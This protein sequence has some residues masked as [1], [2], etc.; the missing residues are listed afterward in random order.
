MPGS[1]GAHTGHPSEPTAAPGY[2]RVAPSGGVPAGAAPPVPAAA[3]TSS[4]QYGLTP[5]QATTRPG[6]PTAGTGP[7]MPTTTG[8]VQPSGPAPVAAPQAFPAAPASPSTDRSAASSLNLDGAPVRLEWWERLGGLF[9]QFRAFR[10][11]TRVRMVLTWV[12]LLIVA[13]TLAVSPLAR[14][15]LG[16]W[17]GCFWIVAV[18]FWLARG[19]TVSWGM[20]SGIFALSMP[21]AGAVGWLSFQVAAAARVPVDHAASQVVIAGVVEEL[22]KLAP[23]CL[24][25]VIA[26]GRVRRLLIQDWLVLGVA[27]G[28]G[29]MAV[30]E[31]ARR[32][33]YVLGNTPGLQLSKAVCPEDPEGIIECI[34]AHTFSLWPFADAFPGPVT[35]A[36]HAIVT[37]LVAVSIGLARHLWW[38]ARHHHPAFGVA[39]RCMALGLPLGVLWVAIVDHMATNSTT[40]STNWFTG[41]RVVKAWGATK[42]EAPWP[43]VGTTSSMAG[44]GQGR[45]WLLLVMLVVALLL[46]ARVMRLGGYA[47]V[48]GGPGGGPGAPQGPTGGVAGRWGADVVEATAAARAKAHRL[49][50]GLAQAATTRRPRLF[51]QAW[52]EHRIA[53]DLAARRALD[54]GPHRWATSALAAAAALAGAWIINT[55]V[56]PAVTELNQRLNGL[57][58]FWFAGI[59]DTLAAV[60][61]SMSPTEKAA[62]VLIGLAAVLL[63]G[64]TLG[65]AVNVG[66]GIATALDAARPASQFMRDPWGATGH[67]LDT[68]N[69]LEIAADAGLAAMAIIPGG[70]ALR[71]AGYAAKTAQAAKPVKRFA[72]AQAHRGLNPRAGIHYPGLRTP[73]PG[74]SDGGPGLWGEGKNYG[75]PRSQAY[76][77]QITRVPIEQSYIVNGVE[78][79]GYD[80]F[81]LIDA[82]GPG[83][84]N[85]IKGDWSNE[86]KSTYKTDPETGEVKRVKKGLLQMGK[87]QVKA[88]RATGTDTPIQWHI[89]EKETFDEL[90]N[91]QKSG[92][93]PAEIELFHTPPN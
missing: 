83:Y 50:L 48:L 79:D 39:L 22:A 87:D 4:G 65:M 21:W 43:I 66:L 81:A 56:P 28:A 16:A 27:C 92:E 70:K 33:T 75:S 85:P 67:Y 77:E 10:V 58:T 91:R 62:L 38:R 47:R 90:F 18:C 15:V 45:G 86:P 63:S 73:R 46:D 55:V 59:L 76:E 74:R 1:S 24:V 35:Y 49:R 14:T 89:A 68:H 52:A 32:L 78:F 23:I 34:Q 31:V 51:L 20:T 26:P 71:G 7:A 19:K 54:A 40:A 3:P 72:R 6:Q 17:I 69:D 11:L 93:F 2:G 88:V 60:W 53:R 44:S 36:G 25:T 29:F 61:E 42:G 5:P 30:E 13:V 37:G 84:A 57:P 41:E 80:G 64:G 8:P 12:S 82:K 9:L